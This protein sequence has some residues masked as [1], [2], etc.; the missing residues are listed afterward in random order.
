MRRI[1]GQIP[2]Q[3]CSLPRQAPVPGCSQGT[4]C[5][6]D[7]SGGQVLPQYIATFLQRDLSE[8]L[9]E[10]TGNDSGLLTGGCKR[11]WQHQFEQ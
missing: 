8:L 1:L 7:L 6:E 2:C 9:V 10:H 4:S 11:S 5:R 3:T